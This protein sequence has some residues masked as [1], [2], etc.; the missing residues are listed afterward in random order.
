MG[1]REWPGMEAAIGCQAGCQ[2]IDLSFAN[3]W[4]VVACLDAERHLL[5]NENWPVWDFGSHESRSVGASTVVLALTSP[6]S[7]SLSL[8]VGWLARVQTAW[9]QRRGGPYAAVRTRRVGVANR[10][11]EEVRMFRRCC[12]GCCQAIEQVPVRGCH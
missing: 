9:L 12:Q 7:R 4:P 10:V 6:L 2:R 8:S 3:L 11:P 1:V 5:A